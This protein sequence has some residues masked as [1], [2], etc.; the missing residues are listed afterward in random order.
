[1]QTIGRISYWLVRNGKVVEHKRTFNKVVDLA[2]PLF[3]NVLREDTLS[4]PI[5]A[6]A[7]GGSTASPVLADTQLGNELFRTSLPASGTNTQ[8]AANILTP[9][10]APYT[11]VITI[12][13]RQ[14]LS[15]FT[16]NS[17]TP[18]AGLAAPL[19]ISEMGLFGGLPVLANP[20]VAPS[21]LTFVADGAASISNGTTVHVGYTWSNQNGE[22][23]ISPTASGTAPGSGGPHKLTFTVPAI[24]PQ[25]TKLTVYAHTSSSVL[26]TSVEVTQ[27]G[28]TSSFTVTCPYYT[29]S[30]A[31]PT[32]NVTV[33]PGP[34]NKGMLF[35]RALIGPVTMQ[36]SDRI[37]IENIITV[38]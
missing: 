12:T 38:G 27:T 3:G 19:V 37:I 4:S 35:N 16:A 5:R 32:S 22:T 17:G 28:S 31:P 34:L 30:G 10:T 23:T 25:A 18:S 7:I 9:A 11:G 24:P 6:I 13:L 33:L 20:T 21:S 14:V 26:K 2:R 1:M 8:L 29:G 15:P 36:S